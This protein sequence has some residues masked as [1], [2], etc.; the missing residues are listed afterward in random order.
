MTPE[1]CFMSCWVW[2]R[3]RTVHLKVWETPQ[4]WELMHGPKDTHLMA[5][6]YCNVGKLRLPGL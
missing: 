2:A 1:D 6:L 5:M 4:L 3:K